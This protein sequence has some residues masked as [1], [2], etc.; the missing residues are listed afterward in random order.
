MTQKDLSQKIIEKISKEKITPKAR[1]RFLLKDYFVWGAG[2]ASLIVGAMAV[3]V[4]L[5]MFKNSGWDLYRQSG[6]GLAK[7]LVASLPYFWL[8]FLGVFIL[9][10]D[11]NLHH[12]KKGYRYSLKTILGVSVLASV[13]LGGVFYNTGLGK[14]ID[15]LFSEN[16]PFYKQMLQHRVLMWQNPKTGLLAGVVIEVK[17]DDS[18]FLED[19]RQGNWQVF[20]ERAV[21]KQ[22]EKGDQ[23]KLFGE[24]IGDK[25]FRAKIIHRLDCPGGNCL[26]MPQMRHLG[27]PNGPFPGGEMPGRMFFIQR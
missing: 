7:F 3:A 4:V 27:P 6:G 23:I 2:V 19:F 22:L 20:T 14:G 11:Y 18:F 24:E 10:F 12:T 21:V 15:K 5:Y 25:V 8:I 9:V 1:W 16:V 13:L 26:Q 17:G